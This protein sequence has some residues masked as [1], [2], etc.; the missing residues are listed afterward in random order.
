MR[1]LRS[2]AEIAG[3]VAPAAVPD[4]LARMD[5]SVAPYP[6]LEPFYFSP[7]KVIESMAAGLPVVASAVGD[8][9]HLIDDGRT[10]RLVAPGVPDALAAV[11]ARLA[12]R[13][14]ERRRLGSA[15]RAHVL[16]EHTWD[17]VVGRLVR[18]AGTERPSL[19]AA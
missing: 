11:L 12:T 10:G 16:R 14:D 3:S 15:A 1:G 2:A 13:P 9:P 6:A 7:L 4:L 19:V 5:A 8:L 17:A 18:L